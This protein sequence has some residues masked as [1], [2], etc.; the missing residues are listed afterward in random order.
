MPKEKRRSSTI[1]RKQSTKFEKF[2]TSP[3]LAKRLVTFLDG[4]VNLRKF[5]TIIDCCCGETGSFVKAVKDVVNHPNVLVYEIFMSKKQKR[6]S[7]TAIEA[8]FLKSKPPSRLNREKTLVV[9]N[10]PFGVNGKT[11]AKFIQKAVEISD[12]IA[13]LLPISFIKDSFLK[14]YVPPE[15]HVIYSKKLYNCE[16]LDKNDE[17]ND[18]EECDCDCKT[19]NNKKKMKEKYVTVNCAFIYFQKKDY[20]RVEKKRRVVSCN[21]F[22]KLLDKNIME[23]RHNADLR[24]RGSGANAGKC[25]QQGDPDFLIDSERSDDYF[26]ELT[27]GMKRYRSK[28]CKQINNSY[29]FKFLN[30]VP[31]I[32][33]L[34]KVQ[35]IKAMNFI[36]NVVRVR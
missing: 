33:Y 31:H 18:N 9:S 14:R 24:I 20:P 8:D 29:S 23:N 4:K 19:C 1:G 28:I 15:F 12:H 35:V 17:D 5:D 36:T 27:R 2:Y 26:I 34:S 16:F 11:A 32:K 21:P 10:V 3:D 6:N 25:F 30:T 7:N 22:F 13:F